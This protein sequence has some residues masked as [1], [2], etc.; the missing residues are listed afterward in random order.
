MR[1]HCINSSYMSEKHSIQRWIFHRKFIWE[2][3]WCFSGTRRTCIS[4]TNVADTIPNHKVIELSDTFLYGM[5]TI[6]LCNNHACLAMWFTDYTKQFNRHETVDYDFSGL[7]Q[8]CGV[9]DGLAMEI[10]VSHWATDLT[11]MIGWKWM[12][13]N[14][15][16]ENVQQGW[17]SGTM[18]GHYD[19]ETYLT[20][21]NQNPFKT[22]FA[23]VTSNIS[24]I[25]P[26][27]NE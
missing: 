4:K 24:G 11:A 16:N 13:W 1:A 6:N 19:N 15:R 8:H 5:V 27:A 12:W 3:L 17:R 26:G 20:H 18:L 23:K 22:T 9:F 10:P 25:F 7:V 2:W 14:Y 21:L